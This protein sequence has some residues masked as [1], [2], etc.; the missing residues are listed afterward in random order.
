MMNAYVK[1]GVV[2]DASWKMHDALRCAVEE[3]VADPLD[4][5]AIRPFRIKK[6]GRTS[7]QGLSRCLPQSKEQVERTGSGY[8][9]GVT[10]GAREQPL[11]GCGSKVQ[12]HISD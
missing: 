3:S 4:A 10:R 9:R 1:I 5:L 12:Y 2:A 7:A 6:L 11:L 8:L